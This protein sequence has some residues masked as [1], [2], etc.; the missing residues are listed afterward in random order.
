MKETP[1]EKLLFL[2]CPVCQGIGYVLTKDCPECNGVSMTAWDGSVLLYW[3]KVIDTKHNLFYKVEKITRSIL[4]SLLILFGAIG[5]LLLFWELFRLSQINSPV[6]LFWQN[7]SDF[8][9]IFWLSLLTDT[10]LIYRISKQYA[11]F[12]HIPKKFSSNVESNIQNISWNETKHLKPEQKLDISKIFSATALQTVTESYEIAKKYKHFKVAPI[13]LFITSLGTNEVVNIFVRLGVSFQ[14]LKNKISHALSAYSVPTH[15]ELHFTKEFYKVLFLA[16]IEAWTQKQKKV[17]MTEILVALEKSSEIIREILFDLDAD[18]TKIENVASWIRFQKNIVSKRR[19]ALTRASVR[20]RGNM[21]RAM[22]AVATPFLNRYSIDLTLMAQ[23]GRLAPCIGRGKII[24]EIFRVIEGGTRRGAILVGP[25]GVGKK[26]IISGI[27]ELM[28][29]EEVPEL[30]RDKRLVGL[31]VA[32]IASGVNAS[33]ASERLLRILHEVIQSKNIILFVNEISRMVGISQGTGSL[34]L[35]TVFS[36]AI[37]SG[38]IIVLATSIPKEYTTHIENS[39]LN[40]VFERVMVQEI[41]GNEAIQILE[42]KTG[43]I[44]YKFQVFFSY[45]S[46]VKSVELADR[47]IHERYLPEKAI[48]I[49]EETA[50]RI[51]RQKG[52]DATVSGEHVA[53]TISEKTE[54][55]LTEITQKESEKLLHLEDQ[56]HKHMVDQN[57][58]VTIVSTAIRRARAQMRNQNRPIVNLLFLGP[59]GVGKTELA[60]TI[61]KVYFGSD[62]ELIRLDMSEYQ[63]KSSIN[64]LIGAPPGSGDSET[65][66]YLTENVRKNPFS[67]VLLDELE[68]AH[69][70]IMNVFLQVMDD[71]RLTDTQGRTID[72]TNVIL[73]ATSNACTPSI[74]EMITQ[75]LSVPEIKNHLMEGELQQHFRPEFLNRFDG[76]VVFKPLSL[77]DVKNIAKLMLLEVEQT[78]GEKGIALQVTEGALEELAQAGYD[79]KFGARP[80]RRVIQEKVSDVL[81]NYI[82]SGEVSRRDTIV[83]DTGNKVEIVKAKS[84]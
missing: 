29:S 14:D 54:I 50:V 73:I 40:Q 78:L 49:L 65:T 62:Q 24:K 26:T 19:R 9:F 71:G 48:E 17:E 63:E 61:I 74:Q 15:Y 1:K 32:K 28:A 2:T 84:L 80:M 47:Y 6:W 11:S 44:E 20:P 37:S 51:H 4:N 76:I 68:K 16:Y 22:T 55:P 81:A 60:K 23:N 30:L 5:A 10:Y 46:I 57:E 69:P 25:P 83:F 39:Q 58:A 45:D 56:I 67:L 77:E 7:N 8:L 41:E 59:T 52:K 75:N 27:A 70:D 3:G 33:E 36:D 79:P 64:R 82:I 38:G 42:A 35:A 18:N 72:F 66:G 43:P 21:N 12:Q 53:Q 31:D 13:H 34:D